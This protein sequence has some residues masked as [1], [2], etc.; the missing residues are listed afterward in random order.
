MCMNILSITKGHMKKVR[1]V[2]ILCTGNSCRSQMAEGLINQY[3]GDK[4]KAWSAGINP[5]SLNPRAVQVMKEIG[6]DISRNRSKSVK[7]FLQWRDL[8]LVI[9]VCDKAKET[10][11]VFSR[12]VKQIHF[13]F[14][15]PSPFTNES[16]DVALPKFRQIRDEIKQ[17]LLNYLSSKSE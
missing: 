10:C 3:L 13:G 17:K 9:T 4:W 11:P 14:E 6:I 7:E 5:S 12:P 8:D 15:D 2:L 1:K 16:D